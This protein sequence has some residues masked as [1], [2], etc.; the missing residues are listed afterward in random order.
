[1]SSELYPF[2]EKQA[3]LYSLGEALENALCPKRFLL[4]PWSTLGMLCQD[5]YTMGLV[6]IVSQSEC[7][8]IKLGLRHSGHGTHCIPV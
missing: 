2:S 8:T 3:L 7:V 1:M 5:W 4:F 6:H